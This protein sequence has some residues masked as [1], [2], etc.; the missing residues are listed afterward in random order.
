MALFA[1]IVGG[2]AYFVWT[3]DIQNPFAQLTAAT[4]VNSAAASIIYLAIGLCCVL[5]VLAPL[6]YALRSGDFF[7]VVVSIV[8]M[9]A[10]FTILTFSRTVIDMVLAAIVYFTSALISVVMFAAAR[11]VKEMRSAAGA[12]EPIVSPPYDRLPGQ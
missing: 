6:I 4:K 8:A 5:A 10:C 2:Y 1:V 7:T 11:I 9:V 3:G 12:A